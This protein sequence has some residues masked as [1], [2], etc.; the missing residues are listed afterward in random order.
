MAPP[1]KVTFLGALQQE[2][3]PLSGSK[4]GVLSN[5]WKWIVRGN[6]RA[7]E[8]RD[9]IGKGLLGREQ[10]HKGTQ[11]SCFAPRL[12]VS[13]FTVIGLVSELSLAT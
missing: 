9:F 13:G 7:D 2:V 12:T 5:T 3:G 4:I 8:A 1:P 10:K 6:T 11:G